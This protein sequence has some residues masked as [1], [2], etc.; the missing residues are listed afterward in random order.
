MRNKK[1]FAQL[2]QMGADFKALA[3][4]MF[5]K[6]FPEFNQKLV[7]FGNTKIFLRL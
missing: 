5:A 6:L 3:Q 4:E 2:E 1:S 7:L